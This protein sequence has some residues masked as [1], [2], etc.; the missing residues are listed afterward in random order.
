LRCFF[1]SS[2][3]RH[4]RWPRDWSSDVCSSDLAGRRRAF[5]VL[6]GLRLLHD[7]LRQGEGGRQ[8]GLR[9]RAVVRRLQAQERLS[10]LV[11]QGREEGRRERRLAL[12]YLKL[13]LPVTQPGPYGPEPGGGGCGAELPSTIWI[14][15]MFSCVPVM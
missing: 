14:T 10:A 13:W 8:E 3:R 15:E 12:Y 1:F 5:G 4:T 11:R 7:R 6:Q 2:R 9:R